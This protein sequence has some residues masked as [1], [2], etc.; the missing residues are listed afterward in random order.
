MNVELARKALFT[1]CNS[2][3]ELDRWIRVFLG[4]RFPDK[5]VSDES[6]SSPLEMIWQLYDHARRNDTAGFK[7]IMAYANR[8]GGKTLGAAVLETMIV[9]HTERNIAHM[10]AIKDQSKKAQEYVKGFFSRPYFMD[11]VVGDNSSEVVVVAHIHRSNGTVVTDAEFSDFTP[12]QKLQYRR[13]ENY[14]RIIACTMQSANGQ[15]VEFFVVDEVDV[16]EKK[17]LRAY[18]QAKGG[19]P[20]S[21]AGMEAMTLFTSTRKSRIGK[22]Q[23]EIDRAPKTGLRLLHWNIIDITEPC[24]PERHVP[25]GPKQTYWINDAEV[26]HIREV[27]YEGLPDSEKHKWYAREGYAGCAKCPIFAACKGRLATEQKGKVGSFEDGGTALLMPIDEVIDKF[28]DATPEFIT[29]EFLCRKPDT[30]GLVYPRLA[31][32]V[33]KK[34][35]NEIARFVDPESTIDNKPDLIRFLAEK[36]ARFATGM[37]FGYNHLFA[38]VTVAIWGNV[39]FVIDAIGLSHQELDDKL[40]LCE[41]LKLWNSTIYADPEDSSSIATFKRKGFRVREWSK[42][43]GSV[44]AG[45]DIV[46]TKLYSKRLGATVYFLKDDPDIELLY[47]HIRDYHYTT[48]PDGKFTEIPDDTNDDLP[49]AFRYCLMNVFGK[50]GALRDLHIATAPVPEANLEHWTKKVERYNANVMGDIVRGLTGQPNR[51]EAEKQHDT[52]PNKIKRGGFFWDG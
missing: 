7:R 45:I 1:P 25:E 23:E 20:T 30:S 51:T 44:R 49:D 47:N 27:E 3:E 22:V 50:N 12:T 21:R 13:K 36:G 10:A 26:R 9:L 8:F 48:G 42:N 15:H 6:T 52:K 2:K 32:E 39:A 11:F 38:V 14:I 4:I 17:N 16:I 24:A 40:A 43:A 41:H 29:T 31:P 18:D 5:I 28:R 19:V 37:D 35:A 33:H 46:R 34:T